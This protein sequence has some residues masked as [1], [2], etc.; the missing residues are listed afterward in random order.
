MN[1]LAILGTLVLAIKILLLRP[2]K[3]RTT[4]Y[5]RILFARFKSTLASLPLSYL[6]YLGP[7][8]KV[9]IGI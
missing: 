3:I 9:S 1:D 7:P 8:L 6:S 4:L 5:L 2:R